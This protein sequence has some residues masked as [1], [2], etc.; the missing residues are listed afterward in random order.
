MNERL[1]SA[2]GATAF[3]ALTNAWPV[4]FD[5]HTSWDERL[6]KVMAKVVHEV[7]V[8]CLTHGRLLLPAPPKQRGIP[9]YEVREHSWFVQYAQ[10]DDGVWFCRSSLVRRHS[11]EWT[12][13][14]PVHNIEFVPPTRADRIID[15]RLPTL[16]QVPTFNQR[17]AKRAAKES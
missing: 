8:D 10:R 16:K 12:R 1:L 15:T 13:W 2:A 11:H 5:R 4:S 9:V 7:I 3:G 6:R 17:F 14:R